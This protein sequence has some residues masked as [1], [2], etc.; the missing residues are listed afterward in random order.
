MMLSHQAMRAEAWT[1][2]R[3]AKLAT[4]SRIN[5]RG[6]ASNQALES[7]APTCN[8]L[9][10]TQ[11][12]GTNA[13]VALLWGASSSELCH[14]HGTYRSKLPGTL[15]GSSG[16]LNCSVAISR[17]IEMQLPRQL[18]RLLGRVRLFTPNPA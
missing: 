3:N 4:E 12:L 14:K 7:A 1:A 16:L 17:G 11:Q 5:M 15:H 6:V 13:G 9:A 8:G 18:W 10:G 2:D